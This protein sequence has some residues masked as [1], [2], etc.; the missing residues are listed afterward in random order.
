ME[1]VILEILVDRNNEKGPGIFEHVLVILHNVF[2]DHAKN[3]VF[4]K[5][6]DQ[7]NFSFEITKIG[8]RIRFFIVSPAKYKNFLKNQIYAHYSDVEVYEVGDYLENIP[9]DKIQVGQLMLSKHYLYP[10]KTFLEIQ[11]DGAGDMVDPFSSITSALGRTGKYTLNTFQINF[12]PVKSKLWKKDAQRLIS[13]LISNYPEYIKK[14]LLSKKFIYLKILLLPFIIIIKLFGLLFTKNSVTLEPDN[15]N[16]NVDNSRVME[17]VELG[18]KKIEIPRVFVSKLNKLGYSTSI[19]IIHAGE[20]K[21][22]ARSS[23]KEIVSTLGIFSGPGQNQLR[24]KNITDKEDVISSVK[25]R[26]IKKGFVFNTGE[27]SGFV[28]LPTTYVKT[29]QINWV[30]ARAFEPPSNLPII[31]PDLGD[32]VVPETDL[33]PF[34]KTNFRGTNIS[35]GIGPDDRRRHIYI[36]GKTGMG[37][38]TLLENMILDDIKKGRG[39]AVIDPHGD[40]A[41]AVI[42]H[43]PKSRTNQTI[44]F[45]PTDTKWPIAFNMLDNVSVEHRSLVASGIVGIF[46]KIFGDSWGPRLEHT[47]RNTI[48]ALL[49]YPNT[50]LI[51]IPLM[52][53]SDVYRSKVVAKITD[54]VVKKFW[55]HEFAKMSPTQKTEAAG[56]ILNKVGQ[57]LSSTILRNILGQPKNSF[58]IRWAMDNKKIIIVNLSKGIIGEDASALLGAMLVTKFQMDAMSRADIPESKREDFYLYVDEF[59]NF[60]TDSFAT[61]LSEARKYK[62]NLVMA[63]QYIDQMQEE[64]KGAVFGNVG[65]LVSFQVGYHDAT[66]LKEVFGKGISEDDLTNLSKYNVYLKQLIDGMPSPVFSAG[67]FAPH[68]KNPEVFEARYNKI[69]QVSREKYSKS[70]ETV[71][72]KINKG[73]KELEEQEEAWEKKKIE[74]DQKKKEEKAKLQAEQKAKQ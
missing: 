36:I 3:G 20:D 40:L 68:A 53:T 30:S 37:K 29:P 62:L 42:G 38:S 18:D 13:I 67:T 1:K 6:G 57:F 22:E 41:E 28:H 7:P 21:V 27:L 33:T 17:E 73:L 64:V 16:E 4:K 43:I 19:N 69:L 31:D 49:E 54:P 14:V 25:N 47:L 58:S 23:I 48:L 2:E 9:S 32:D 55:T 70:K 45:D 74:L 66:I 39:V 63:N 72:A 26:E 10:I 44:I 56:P 15:G 24:L 5:S 12:S 11:E 50:T 34:G 60:A 65:S 61:I 46:K 52:L 8:N 35:F 71:E 51:S 59:Q